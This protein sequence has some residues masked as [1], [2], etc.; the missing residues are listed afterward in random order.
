MDAMVQANFMYVFL[1]IQTPSAEA[2]RAPSNSRIVRGILQN[3]SSIRERRAF[4][5]GGFI[6]GFDTRR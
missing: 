2:L 3:N 5:L 4:V 6:V 1:G